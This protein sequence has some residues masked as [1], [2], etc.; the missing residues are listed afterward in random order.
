MAAKN[1]IREKEAFYKN[2]KILGLVTQVS[3]HRLAWLLNHEF[4]WDLVREG[5]LIIKDN[6]SILVKID[7]ELKENEQ[8]PQFPIQS[9]YEEGDRYQVDLIDNKNGSSAFLPELKQF[10][11]ILLLH[12]EFDYLPQDLIA[13]MNRFD[14]I[15]IVANIEH[16]KIKNKNLLQSYR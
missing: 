11:Y 8:L 12:G 10:D 6:C 5:E 7:D 9:Y 1:I 16:I 2:Y 3:L 13:R 4:D 15:Q 14:H